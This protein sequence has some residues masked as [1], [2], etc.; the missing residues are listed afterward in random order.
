MVT[1]KVGEDPNQ[2]DNTQMVVH[3][4]KEVLIIRVDIETAPLQTGGAV[5]VLHYSDFLLSN[6]YMNGLSRCY[7]LLFTSLC[8]KYRLL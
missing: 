4:N 2:R 1:H 3:Q 7:K 6:P 8:R 5:L